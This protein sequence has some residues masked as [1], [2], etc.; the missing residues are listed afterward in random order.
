VRPAV[1]FASVKP[2]KADAKSPLSRLA[3]AEFCENPVRSSGH[4]PIPL[5]DEPIPQHRTGS[6]H[7]KTLKTTEKVLIITVKML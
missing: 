5:F 2:H 6:K 4:E 1:F 7:R 3:N